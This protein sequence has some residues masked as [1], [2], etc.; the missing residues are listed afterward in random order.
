M[1]G[2][3]S[4]ANRILSTALVRADEFLANPANHRLHPQAQQEALG[5]AVNHVGLVAPVVVNKRSAPEWGIDRGIETL[6]DGHLRVTMALR[7][8]DDTELPVVYVDLLPDEER[9]I[10]A[11]LDA[12]GAMAVEDAAK[13]AELVQSVES[14]N[15]DIVRLLAQ[16][17]GERMPETQE[18]TPPSER[19]SVTCPECGHVWEP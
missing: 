15:A 17:A 14:E 2:C 4:W 19:Q 8:G 18:V 16:C 6:L 12:I 1:K 10:L 3:M 11:S 7:D 5:A 13:L 9:I